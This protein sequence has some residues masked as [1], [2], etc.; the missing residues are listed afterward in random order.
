[1]IKKRKAEP[2]WRGDICLES[3]HLRGWGQGDHKFEASLG[4]RS[5]FKTT[6][7]AEPVF[8]P[9]VLKLQNF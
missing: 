9:K 4:L 7:K 1:M 5:F 6:T 8:E 3:W 2:T